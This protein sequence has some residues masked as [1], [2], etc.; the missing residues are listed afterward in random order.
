MKQYA[1]FLIVKWLC[2]DDNK[3]TLY[4]YD[5]CI[6]RLVCHVL[7]VYQYGAIYYLFFNFNDFA[8]LVIN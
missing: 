2:C 5:R 4:V 3:L 6:L 7:L 1:V 8:V